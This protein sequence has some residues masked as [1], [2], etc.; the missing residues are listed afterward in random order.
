MSFNFACSNC[1]DVIESG[2]NDDCLT[3]LQRAGEDLDNAWCT[4]CWEETH[5]RSCG[6]SSDD[7][8]GYDGLCG[9]CA[10]R[11]ENTHPHAVAWMG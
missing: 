5:C 1:G 4:D 9:N 6:S 11:V 2:Y 8:E 3:P 7:G 10:D